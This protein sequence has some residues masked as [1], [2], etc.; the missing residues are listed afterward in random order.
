MLRIATYSHRRGDTVHY[1]SFLNEVMT[2]AR[3]LRLV[4]LPDDQHV[5]HFSDTICFLPVI[6]VSRACNL[7]HFRFFFSQAVG[8]R[9]KTVQCLR[10]SL[11][12]HFL[13]RVG[14]LVVSDPQVLV[15]MVFCYTYEGLFEFKSLIVI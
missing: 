2:R 1:T 6:T 3:R 7:G 13:Q 8:I 4:V 5:G 15:R 12:M 9:S 11:L 14:L 10:K